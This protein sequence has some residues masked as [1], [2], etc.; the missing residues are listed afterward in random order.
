MNAQKDISNAVADF[1]LR[2]YSAVRNQPPMRWMVRLFENVIAD[3]YPR[4]VDLPT[5]AGKT[6]VVVIWLLALA[7][8]GLNGRKS[9]PVPRRLVWVVNRRVLVQQVFRIAETLRQKLAS[10][11]SPQ[12]DAVRAGLRDLSGSEVEIFNIV[13]L[14]G[15][16]VADRE[17]GIRPAVPQL[18][19]GTVD[20]IGSRLLFQGYGLGKWGRPQQAG[21]LGVD[22][23]I[24]VDEAHLV[25]AFV[26]TLRQLRDRCTPLENLPAPFNS[27][28]ARLPL[29]LTELS[30]TPGL[31][32]PSAAAPFSL[33]EEDGDDSAIADRILAAGTRR[34][35]VVK[36]PKGDKP[37][38]I[39]VNALI[40][41]AIKSKATR[42]AVFVREVGVADSVAKAI[43]KAGVEPR[44]ICKITG[45]VRGY[46]RD[47]IAKHPA[48]QEFVAER[49]LVS[50]STENARFFLVGTAAAEV[51]LDA[52]ADEILC[53]FASLPTLLQRLG[54]LDRRGV[55]SR[56]HEDGKGDAPTMYVFAAPHDI[57]EKT[58]REAAKVANLLKA[59][60]GPWSARLLAGTHWLVEEK[61]ATAREEAAEETKGKAA[62]NRTDSLIE[63][64]T[65][66]VL[67][68]VSGKCKPPNRWL[69]DDLARVAAG[70]VVVP[71]LTDTVLDYWSATTDA[72]S[73]KLSPHPFL[74]GLD[75]GDEGTPLVGV[76]FRLEV[77]AL[78]ESAADEDDLETPTPATGV[79]EIFKRFPPLRAELHQVKLSTVR[80]WLAAPGADRHPFIYR[81]RDTWR[82]KF[83]GESN[84]AALRALGP[85]GTLVLP[86]SASMAAPCKKLI[87]DSEQGDMANVAIS[88]VLDGVSDRNLARYRRTIEPAS[89]R[90]CTDGA[91]LWTDDA[92]AG[93][94]ATRTGIPD[95]FKRSL[96]KYLRIG[97]REYTFRYCR[98]AQE[99]LGRQFLDDHDEKDGHLTR[100][101]AE[102]TRLAAAIAPDDAFLREL[103]SAA[104]RH[105]DEGKRLRKWQIAFGWRTGPAIAKLEPTLDRPAPLHGFRHEWESLRKLIGVAVSP[106]PDISSDA[107]ALW[108]VLLLHFVGVHHGHLRPSITDDGLTPEIQAEKQNAL[109]LESAERFMRLQRQLG[110]WRLAYLEALLKTADAVGSRAIPG[111]EEDET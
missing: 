97:G 71:P 106:P 43:A 51:G 104:A 72:R 102:T 27:I 67:A 10:D 39:L 4:S 20:Q 88:D 90:T 93:D 17:W 35:H 58:H 61:G 30:A 21:L 8:F 29:W 11:E 111:Y 59:E 45:R 9:T 91:C 38:D 98:P 28:F 31:S 7:W 82:A 85:N 46:E 49:Q 37:K 95:G 68:N 87:E 5:G 81:H 2:N 15:Q 65:L 64:A 56:R 36:L 57:K 73:P 101:A 76:A 6:E 53:D 44:C 78:R 16:I 18:I 47:R 22:S 19:I 55:L 89:G 62:K 34:V 109:R 66:K 23:W 70:P 63:A 80:E 25:P 69:G 24:A 94:A 77:E 3:R 41:E 12:L 107:Q 14:R 40:K 48:F 50:T 96:L 100:A 32:R 42:V 33:I 54:R 60:T 110:R 84:A 1:F 103:L 75:E 105:H 52:D 13:E 86:A 79:V 83:V 99:N 92:E 108:S 26:V 74:Y